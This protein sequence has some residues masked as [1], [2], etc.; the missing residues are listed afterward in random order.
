[1]PI[2]RKRSQP[3]APRSPSDGRSTATR[4]STRERRP[5]P[6]TPYGASPLL[7]TR[8]TP[9]AGGDSRLRQSEFKGWQ[10]FEI[11]DTDDSNNDKSPTPR[12]ASPDAITVMPRAI[13]YA[14]TQA[15]G[16]ST[17]DDLPGLE[18]WTKGKGMNDEKINNIK[19]FLRASKGWDAELKDTISA[20]NFEEQPEYMA[21]IM[22]RCRFTG[23]SHHD[24]ESL[25]LSVDRLIKYAESDAHRSIVFNHATRGL[26]LCKDHTSD[27]LSN[28][29]QTRLKDFKVCGHTILSEHWVL[30]EDEQR[31]YTRQI[32]ES[33]NLMCDVKIPIWEEKQSDGSWKELYLFR[34]IGPDTSASEPP[35]HLCSLVS[36]LETD[37]KW[38]G[39]D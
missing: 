15:S 9:L 11:S 4:S 19:H 33:Q 28:L 21:D 37:D 30:K 12:E 10:Y 29:P 25:N 13:R 8:P 36:T 27:E 38:V 2:L 26:S 5:P 32:L 7:S 31:A 34:S 24:L 18:H 20:L 16:V 1:M 35:T 39:R 14:L 23:C 22:A 3:S 17:D 6:S